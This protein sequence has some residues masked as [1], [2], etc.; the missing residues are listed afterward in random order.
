M[1]ETTS[2]E[3]RHSGGGREP[4]H[5]GYAETDVGDDTDATPPPA[6]EHAGQEDCERLPGYRHRAPRNSDPE[7]SGET[8]D[9]GHANGQGQLHR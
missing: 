9:G 7:L 2:A 1:G 3:R 6:K 5:A 8:G 4:G